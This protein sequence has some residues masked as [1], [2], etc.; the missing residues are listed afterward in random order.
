M[1]QETPE[2]QIPEGAEAPKEK[3]KDD[4]GIYV[5]KF[6]SRSKLF[7]YWPVWVISFV[8]A[9]VSYI[10]GKPIFLQLGS[11][12]A[13]YKALDAYSVASPGLGLAFLL[14]LLAVILF[15]SVNIRGL[16]AALFAFA[17]IIIALLMSIFGAWGKVLSFF[18]GMYFYLNMQF[19]LVLGVGLF[20]LWLLV[21]FLF[22]RRKYVEF[23][24]TQ[25]TIVQEVGDGEK[26][27][28]TVG[29]VFDKKRDNFFQH[30]LLGFGS[31]DLLITTSG[32]VRDHIEFPNV[33]FIGRR[34]KQ[35]HHIRERRGR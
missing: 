16:W 1:S 12:A 18:G 20:I 22:D 33:L 28:D 5:L 10:W 2:A 29:L 35:I 25:L 32:G 26:N 14:V 8:F 17:V 19:Y 3:P 4:Q 24:P 21:V 15:T 23:R 34:I 11:K 7:Y 6:Y 9:L 31:G 27:F 30:W 13:D